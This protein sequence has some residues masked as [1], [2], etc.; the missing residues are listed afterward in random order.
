M[1]IGIDKGCL[2]GRVGAIFIQSKSIA[3]SSAEL[4]GN[5]SLLKI[6]SWKQ[7]SKNTYQNSIRQ[8]QN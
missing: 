7:K 4:I 1:A 8:Q 2:T 3:Q 5:R 6:C